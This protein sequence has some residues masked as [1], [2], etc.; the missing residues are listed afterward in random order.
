MMNKKDMAWLS[1]FLIAFSLLCV[2][3][4]ASLAP[5]GPDRIINLTTETSPVRGAFMLNTSGGT[6]TTVK[7]NITAQTYRWKAYVGNVTGKFTLDDSRNY[8]IYDWSIST[9]AG[10]VYATRSSTLVNWQSIQCANNNSI[11]LEEIALN[12]SRSND[13]SIN[14]T[15]N[16]KPYS[17]DEFYVAA[18]KFNANSCPATSTYVNSTRQSA[19]F[20]EVVLFDAANI[21]YAG[22]LE[23]KI[24]G[25]DNNYYDFQLI[26]PESGL[27]GSQA[28]TAYYFYVELT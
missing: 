2:L 8:T 7:I 22:I 23:S 25:F 1:V 26:V 11:R 28:P 17:H 16:R 13:D 19:V 4:A 9:V 6:F 3:P 10:E 18:T 14:R 20:Q 5:T 24:R 12:I 15:F 21:V 27:E